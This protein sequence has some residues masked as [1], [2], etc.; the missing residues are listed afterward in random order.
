[1]FHLQS[2]CCS[3]GVENSKDAVCPAPALDTACTLN[4]YVVFSFNEL[5]LSDLVSCKKE[6][7]WR[8]NKDDEEDGEGDG[9]KQV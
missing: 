3:I 8:R 9:N 7:L 5:M 1:M 2:A 4:M 6:I